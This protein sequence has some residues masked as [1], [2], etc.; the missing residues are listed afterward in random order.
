MTSDRQKCLDAGCDDY[1][2]KPINQPKLIQMIASYAAKAQDQ[3]T[4]GLALAPLAEL[5]QAV[6][7]GRSANTISQGDSA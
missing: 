1:L 7:A 6:I 4:A 2:T 3:E 5:S